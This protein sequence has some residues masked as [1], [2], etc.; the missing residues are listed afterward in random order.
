LRQWRTCFF[1]TPYS[2]VRPQVCLGR[3][4]VLFP[5]QCLDPPVCQLHPIP[6]NTPLFT[7]SP[8]ATAAPQQPPLASAPF[9]LQTPLLFC[10]FPLFPTCLPTPFP[11][12]SQFDHPFAVCCVTNHV[13]SQRVSS[14]FAT[15]FFLGFF[16]FPLFP[17]PDI[18]VLAFSFLIFLGQFYSFL[19]MGQL[20][21]QLFSPFNPP[22]PSYPLPSTWLVFH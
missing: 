16:P 3:L 20:P 13:N 22:F 17:P 9:F 15:F 2:V 8:A 5:P 7:T 10:P 6:H 4:S 19:V 21:S 12:K 1:L 14:W 11:P 18:F